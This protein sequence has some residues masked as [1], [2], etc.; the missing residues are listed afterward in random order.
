MRDKDEFASPA[1]SGLGLFASPSL[2]LSVA[3]A[4][5][6]SGIAAARRHQALLLELLKANQL[7]Q[8]FVASSALGAAQ[9]IFRGGRSG[10]GAG[11]ARGSGRSS[12]TSYTGGG[13]GFG[14]P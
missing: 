5:V 7:L 2:P 4:V 1:R 9:R 10:G 6:A 3:V 8:A 14:R 11:G 13:G 12:T